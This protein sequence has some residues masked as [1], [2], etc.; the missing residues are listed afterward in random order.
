[1]PTTGEVRRLG[2]RR[3]RDAEER[4]LGHRRSMESS[5][6]WS[7]DSSAGGAA[8][9]PAA[10][11]VILNRVGTRGDYDDVST[12]ATSCTSTGEPIAVSFEL[13]KPPATS[14]LILHW[15]EGPNPSE[16]NLSH[17]HLLAAHGNKLLFQITIPPS[18][19]S[20]GPIN[21]FVYQAADSQSSSDSSPPSQLF[22]LPTCPE[23]SGWATVHPLQ[24]I[25]DRKGTGI[26]SQSKESFIVAELE[27]CSLL[28]ANLW[29]FFSKYGRW[30]L[31]EHLRI[32]NA[33]SHDLYWWATDATLCYG[34]QMIWVDYYRGMIFADLSNPEN[35]ELWY[36]TLPVEPIRGN[37]EHPDFDRGCP[38]ATRNVCV[39]GS[40]IKFII[41]DGVAGKS[42]GSIKIWSLSKI[43]CWREQAVL[44][45]AQLWCLDSSNCLPH[46]VPRFPVVSMEN[47]NVVYFMARNAGRSADLDPT[48]WLVEV[49]MDKKVLL[50]TTS[51]KEG[52]PFHG[53]TK[54]PAMKKP[55]RS[56]KEGSLLDENAKFAR[57]MSESYS[58]IPCKIPVYMCKKDEV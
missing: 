9:N 42:F 27:I 18:K 22:R 19:E 38:G 44:T 20:F 41:I 31:L 26:M 36:V 58:F 54:T 35:P 45:A 2:H 23:R 16:S 49:D 24:H 55:K 28:E 30:K 4:D 33:D 48:T 37:P 17:P 13:V 25:M 57:K 7:A 47:P 5:A 12:R 52:S 11:W 53:I 8:C 21:Y 56:Y 40:R 14:M 15:P 34:Q 51:Y 46:N 10:S 3:S 32:R 39:S 1:M 29:A 50:A 43:C 6:G